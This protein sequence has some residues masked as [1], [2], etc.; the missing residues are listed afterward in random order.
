M[1]RKQFALLAALAL[2]V[3]GC[4][5]NEDSRSTTGA[6]VIT[7]K[8]AIKVLR[9]H[10]FSVTAADGGD[11]T[12]FGGPASIIANLDFS[13]SGSIS[14]GLVMCVLATGT[15]QQRLDVEK[16]YKSLMSSGENKRVPLH[17]VNNLHCGY[18]G[19]EELAPEP[20]EDTAVCKPAFESAMRELGA[21][22]DAEPDVVCAASPLLAER[23]Q[24]NDR[25]KV[26]DTAYVVGRPRRSKATSEDGT[27]TFR[28]SVENLGRKD[29]RLR[30]DS[31]DYSAQSCTEPSA[32]D[33]SI[34]TGGTLHK[35]TI[36]AGEKVA[37]T[38]VLSASPDTD[39]TTAHLELHDLH[40]DKFAYVVNLGLTERCSG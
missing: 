34:V 16:K 15:T 19:D 14:E 37:G 8:Q 10:G 4:A 25:V 13:D 6:T 9:A 36:R 3:G 30:W 33:S 1:P 21:D 39:E 29:A 24:I 17:S 28:I 20:G 23:A 35:R 2:L 31:I 38:A 11:K 32:R 18:V 7:A 26:G 40:S 5:S 22:V 27:V 12:E